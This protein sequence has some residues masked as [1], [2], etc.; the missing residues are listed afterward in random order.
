[1]LG[2]QQAEVRRVPVLVAPVEHLGVG[3]RHL[4]ANLAGREVVRGDGS[5]EHVGKADRLDL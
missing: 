4:L 3:V 2:S 5:V 1:M